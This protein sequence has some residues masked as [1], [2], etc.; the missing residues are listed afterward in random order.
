MRML[1]EHEL[2][3]A[4]A[5]LG[6]SLAQTIPTDDQIIMQHVRDAHAILQRGILGKVAESSATWV[7]GD[8]VQYQDCMW[9]VI[10]SD[11]TKVCIR[12]VAG[13][14]TQIVPVGNVEA[15]RG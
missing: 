9:N 1:T 4:C 2:R 10:W 5:H 12:P 3:E 11:G 13:T 7:Y 14:E 8:Y 6:A 15:C